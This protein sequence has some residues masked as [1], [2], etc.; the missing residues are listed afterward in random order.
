MLIDRRASRSEKKCQHAVRLLSIQSPAP[1]LAAGFVSLFLRLGS[2]DTKRIFPHQLLQLRLDNRDSL[3]GKLTGL[4][5]ECG[6][7]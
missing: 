7:L 1:R 3:P 4:R 2:F 6:R 5:K